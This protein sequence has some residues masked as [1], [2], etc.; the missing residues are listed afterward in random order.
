MPWL[1]VSIPADEATQEVLVA[2]LSELGYESFWQDEGVLRAYIHAEL[3]DVLALGALCAELN[4]MADD[5]VAMPN[6]NWNAE[7]EAQ[8][9]PVSVGTFVYIHPE[10]MPADTS[11]RMTL[12]I[13]PQ[14]AFGTGHHSTTRLCAAALEHLPV[15]GARVLDLGCGTGVLG[16]LAL[17][18][19]AAHATLVDIEPW[20]AENA[21]ENL[22]RNQL[23]PARA[24]IIEGTAADISGGTFDLILANLNRN[25]LLEHG[26]FFAERLAQGGTLLTSGYFDVDGPRIVE[27]FSTHGLTH[28][29]TST[30]EPW[31]CQQFARTV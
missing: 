4:V 31:L 14:M 23:D 5:P 7:W 6:L 12:C 22:R 26:A 27:H 10:H 2:Q 24:T 29:R 8:W 30:E 28:I 1:E 11:F 17:K 13:Q 18:L 25:L 19:G 9:Q 20:A 21:A 3:Y 16:L 15:A